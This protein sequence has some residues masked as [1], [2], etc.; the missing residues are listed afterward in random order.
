MNDMKIQN[1]MAQALQEPSPPESLVSRTIVRAQA[2]VEGRQA[3]RRLAEGSFDAEEK[4][5][6][7]AQRLVGRVMLPNV[8][9]EGAS[10]AL[11]KDQLLENKEFRQMTERPAEQLLSELQTGRMIRSLGEQK[12]FRAEKK[13]PAVEKKQPT[14]ENPM[15]SKGGPSL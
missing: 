4:A 3:E 1:K 2:L 14:L 11:M 13:T 8:P 12:Y 5:Q 15:R 7:A 6:L 9:P 10:V